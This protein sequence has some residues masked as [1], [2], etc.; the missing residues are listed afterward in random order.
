V[1]KQ[2]REKQ[3]GTNDPTHFVPMPRSRLPTLSSRDTEI[4]AMLCLRVRLASVMQI[5]QTWWGGGEA[6]LNVCCRRLCH[7][8]NAGLLVRKRV[9]VIAVPFL[10]APLVS[11]SPRSVTPDLGSLAWQ[12]R[13]RWRTPPQSTAIYMATCCCARYFGGRRRGR[14]PRAFQVSH[15]LGVTAMFLAVRRRNPELVNYWVDEDRFAPYR[16]GQ[17]LPDAVIIHCPEELPTLVLEFGGN[18]SKSRL[19]AFH[20]DNESRGLPYEIW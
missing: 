15:D 10:T 19:Q 11:W 18:Y 17:K 6:G 4:L 14:I 3:F 12:L 2:C 16:R 13:R 20:E 8:E 1:P 5:A 7:L 9:A